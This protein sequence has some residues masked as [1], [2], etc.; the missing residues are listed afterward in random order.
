MNKRILILI[1]LISISF[2]ANSQT[3]LPALE[4]NWQRVQI[5]GVGSID[6]PPTL[7]IQ[8]GNYKVMADGI[9][10]VS[11]LYANSFVAQ[12]KGIGTSSSKYARVIVRTTKGS[13]GDFDKLYFNI[14][15]Y[16]ASDISELNLMY[17]EMLTSNFSANNILI[18][19]WY[20]LIVEKVNGMSCVHI[21]YIR[22][23]S[24]N[25]AVLVNLYVFHNNDRMHELT[26]SYR[27]DDSYYYKSDF[28][29]ILKSFRITNV[30]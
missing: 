27:V 22:K 9:K 20:P 29:K 6:L 18:T 15:D 3:K 23:L 17:R 10:K 30:R 5:E 4:S 13:Y 28:E 25:P 1:S 16:S 7:E 2:Y 11:G 14:N 12:Q 8:S 21:S 19:K 24:T 26:L